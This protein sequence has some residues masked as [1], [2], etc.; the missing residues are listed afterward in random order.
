MK[1]NELGFIFPIK[2]EQKIRNFY[3]K[4]QILYE[5][6]NFKNIPQV[7]SSSINKM[8]NGNNCWICE[9]WN[10]VEFC[11]EINNKNIKP[12]FIVV[13][14]HLDFEN[15]APCDM[16]FKKKSFKLVRMCPP[17]K[18]KFFFTVDG[19]PVYNCYKEFD[20]KIREFE[21]PIKYTFNEEFIEHFNNIKF[22]D[23]DSDENDNTFFSINKNYL[24]NNININ[25]QEDKR[26]ENNKLI[27]KTI[28]VKNYG[29]RIIKPNNNI[30]TKEYKSTLKF[31]VPR[32]EDISSVMTAQNLW[33]F[34]NSFWSYYNYNF[35]GETDDTLEKMFETDFNLVEY[36]SIFVN[37]SEL[38]LVKKLLKEYYK[39]IINCY[40]T[41]SSKSGNNNVWQITS[42]IM[43]EWLENRCD[44]FLTKEYDGKRIEKIFDKIYRDKKEEKLRSRYKKYFPK[45]LKN[46]IRHNFILFLVEASI[47]KYYNLKHKIENH[48]DA[49]KYSMENFFM[50]GFENYEYHTWR[51][52]RYYTEDIDNYLKAFLPLI[53]GV[54][55]T[56]SKKLAH[57][58]SDEDMKMTL[59]DFSNLIKSFI[60]IEDFDMSELPIIFHISKKYTINEI[61][62]DNF[63]YL[64][65]EEFCE[66]LCRV[67]DI[68]S[69]YPPEEEEDNWPL[70]KR[71]EQFLIEKLENIMPNLYKKINHPKYNLIRD[72]F[73]APLKNQIT[74]LY[75]IDYK[76]SS[77]YKGYEAIFEHNI[78]NNN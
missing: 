58:K 47:D 69:P 68:Y 13:K 17:G 2:K 45:N 76:N 65:F 12:K 48:Y 16:I 42:D 50:K 33:K 67:I 49:L 21:K 72:K 53:D 37:E 56:F 11:L 52:E 62:D 75:I 61:S 30:V 8:R 3:S 73:I 57:E 7:L 10:E 15:Y 35:D 20:Y 64:S 54:F 63:M 78:V 9:C 1:I 60:N 38:I 39:K 14:L 19:N 46:L 31:S 74:S 77:F 66:A 43:L 71:K 22:I 6:E 23:L 55:H 51:K 26:D 44:N 41:L 40:I 28:Y 59:E 34:S 36:K 29:F 4:S 5:A 27:S 24:G 32:P 25:I 18:V 70:E